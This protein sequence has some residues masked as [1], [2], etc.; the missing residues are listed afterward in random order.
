MVPGAA[1]RCWT[2]HLRD[3][4]R[5]V[6]FGAGGDVGD[7]DG[8]VELPF[9]R[10]AHALQRAG[11]AG[12]GAGGRRRSRTGLLDVTLSAMRGQRIELPGRSSSSTTATT[13]TRCR[14][15]PPSTILPR[16]RPGAASPCSGTCSSSGP[17][18]R[19]FHE[20]IGAHAEQAGVDVLVDRRTAGRAHGAS[21]SVASCTPS[22]TRRR[23]LSSSGELVRPGDTVLVKASRGVGL[24]VVAPACARRRCRPDGRGPDRRHGR[25]ADLHLPVAEVHRRSCASASSASTSARRG[26]RATTARRGRRRWAGSS[27]SR[28]SRSRF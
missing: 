7:L 26:R 20:Q 15:A 21:A 6:T 22:A 3:D 2:P 27:S 5:G 10:R 14:C 18:R 23:P 17:T 16:P 1:S 8:D 9:Q 28:R 24:E 4:V 12:R 13:P 11:R 25:A 19:S